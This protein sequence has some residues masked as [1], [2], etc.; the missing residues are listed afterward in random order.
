[1]T[2]R[3]LPSCL[4]IKKS[5]ID[6]LGLY[7]TANIPA[8]ER[9]GISHVKHELFPN[10][11]IRTPLGGFYNHSENPNC[12]NQ[13]TALPDGGEALILVTLRDIQAGEE[14]TAFYSLY[15]PS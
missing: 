12:E 4:T 2:Y 1:M 3:P 6:G 11:Y 14:L 15:Q 7:A 5:P 13:T 8:G 9:L 10:G